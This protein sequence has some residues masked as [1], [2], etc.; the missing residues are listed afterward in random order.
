MRSWACMLLA[1]CYSATPAAGVPCDPSAPSC[2]SG[3]QCVARGG[4]FVC[5]SDVGDPPIDGTPIDTSSVT[6]VDGDGVPNATDNCPLIANA[7]QANEDGDTFGDLCD[8]CPPFPST[9]ADA[10]GDGVGDACDPH[11][12]IPGDSIALFEGFAGTAIPGG[13][14]AT[15]T[16]SV[17]NGSL[18]ASAAGDTLSTLVVPYAA[19]A[20]QTIS[21]AATITALTQAGGGSIGIVDRFDGTNGLHCG[22][23]RLSTT[24]LFGLIDAATGTFLSGPMPHPFEVNTLY[25]LTFT[26]SADKTYQCS[27][28]QVNGDMLTA[29]TTFDK[30]AGTHIGFRN[31]VASASY[32]WIMV[33]KSP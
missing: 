31:R 2:P 30:N 29:N 14:T 28:V 8:D 4:A 21:S 13:W 1:G 11:V 32:A 3:Q 25:R 17:A 12:L 24:G 16:W 22:G 5:D 6:D 27:T 20:N 9:G 33:V 26:R 15:G 10:D 19:T 7:N 23:G 18:I